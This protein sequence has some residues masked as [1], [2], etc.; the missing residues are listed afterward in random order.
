MLCINVVYECF[1]HVSYMYSRCSNNLKLCIKD[2]DTSQ[3]SNF[4]CCHTC[5]KI[6]ADFAMDLK[7][8][9][10]E[11]FFYYVG[12]E[13][14]KRPDTYYWINVAIVLCENNIFTF[15]QRFLLR[16]TMILRPLYIKVCSQLCKSLFYH[17][18]FPQPSVNDSLFGYF[19]NTCKVIIKMRIVF[20][21]NSKCMQATLNKVLNHWWNLWIFN[22]TVLSWQSGLQPVKTSYKFTFPVVPHKSSAKDDVF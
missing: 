15:D 14:S 13:I 6:S 10:K 17:L 21:Y 19:F 22:N 1:L 20:V 5:S 11:S 12:L 16:S 4:V 8:P 18:R 7:I 2:H 9:Q 3:I